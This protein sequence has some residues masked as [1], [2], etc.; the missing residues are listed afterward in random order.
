MKMTEIINSISELNKDTTISEFINKC[1][2]LSKSENIDSKIINWF[3]DL[4]LT[5][6]DELKLYAELHNFSFKTIIHK[7]YI[8]KENDCIY[9]KFGAGQ[10]KYKD[11]ILTIFLPTEFNPKSLLIQR[12]FY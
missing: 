10:L 8:V 12:S 7:N 11:V 1:V 4:K 3:V 9:V 6:E 2:E 5:I